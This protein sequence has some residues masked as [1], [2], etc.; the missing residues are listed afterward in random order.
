MVE[1]SVGLGRGGVLK[2]SLKKKSQPHTSLFKSCITAPSVA[3]GSQE[4]SILAQRAAAAATAL[5]TA[6]QRNSAA[7]QPSGGQ[8]FDIDSYRTARLAAVQPNI[9]ECAEVAEG[10]LRSEELA[11][12]PKGPLFCLSTH[13][14]PL[15]P[16]PINFCPLPVNPCPRPRRARPRSRATCPLRSGFSRAVRRAPRSG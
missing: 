3:A 15:L 5:Q 8:V 10:P 2:E 7:P 4:E 6:K 12:S 13:T 11:P 14:P 9:M 16:L 1:G